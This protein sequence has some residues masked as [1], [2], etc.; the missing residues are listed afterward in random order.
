MSLSE[1]K[2]SNA[3]QLKEL[4]AK[5]SSVK[6][7]LTKFKKHLDVVC[8]SKLSKM[9]VKELEISIDKIRAMSSK[10]DELQAQIEVINCDNMDSEI[11]ERDEIEQIFISHLAI[12]E[13]QLDKYKATPHHSDSHNL[14][15]CH[16][17]Q[18]SQCHH[19]DFKL[20]QIQ[21]T[22]F[23]GEY[24]RWLE[25]RDTYL[26]LIHNNER[27]KPIHKFHYLVSYLE[28]EAAR[29]ISNLEICAVN[30]ETAW[31][32]LCDR[33]DN[34]RQLINQHLN[35]LLYFKPTEQQ[36]KRETGKSLRFL[37]DHVTKNL[38]ALSSLAKQDE[39]LDMII[40]KMLIP[41]LDNHTAM[42]WEEHRNCLSDLPTLKDFNKFLNDRADVLE[43]LS[44]NKSD[45][46]ETTQPRQNNKNNSRITKS[47]S[48]T[49]QNTGSVTRHCVACKG[50]HWIYDC[51]TFLAKSVQER[52]DEAFKLH[53]CSNCLRIG[54][55]ARDCKLGPCRQCK[56]RH[57]SLLHLPNSNNSSTSN[58][59]TVSGNSPNSDRGFSEI[60]VNNSTS[61]NFVQN[62]ILLSTAMVN[63]INPQT[64]KQFRVRALLDC[65]S[66]SSFISQSLM[67]KLSLQV[68]AINT[69][70]V[71]GIGNN[72][73]EH[74]NKS[75]IA[76][77]NSV[78]NEY[79]VVQ[80]FYV[81]N[82]LTG[83]IPKQSIDISQ[84]NIP[85]D[86]QLADPNFN[87]PSAIDILIGADLFWD[88]LGCD[89]LALGHNMPKLRSSKLGWLVAGPIS[90][91][92]RNRSSPKTIPCHVSINDSDECNNSDI[93][94][95]LTKFWEL[96]QVP[97]KQYFSK[98]EQACEDHFYR[99]T[100][101]LE[102]GRFCV[103]LPLI[104]TPDCLGDSY[105]M[106]KTR[107]LYLEKRFRK[108]PELRLQYSN[109]IQEY[110]D[111]GHLEECP[112]VHP[113]PS[114]YLCHHAV[115]KQNSETTKTRVVFDG[116]ARTSSG[117]SLNDL[118]M[119]GPN[120]Q[121]SIF[122]ILIRARQY[123]YI[124]TADI[125]KFFRMV[126]LDERD[127]NFQLI[128]WRSHESNPIKTLRLKTVTYGLASA[129]YLSTKCLSVLAEDCDDQLIS[130]IIKHDHYVDD[131][132][133][134]SNN[135]SELLYIQRKVSDTLK[136][137]G[138]KLRKFRSN[139][140]SILSSS[141]I[142]P[143]DKVSLSES[144]NTLGLN[145]NPKTD[146]F[147]IS[148]V[149]PNK[150]DVVTKRFIL[151][152]S[153]K[154]FDPLGLL[155]PCVIIPKMLLQS[156]WLN[157]RSWDETVSSDILETWNKFINDLH[158]LS[159]LQ[160]PRLT[161]CEDPSYIEI[162]TFSDASQVAYGACVYL[163]SHNLA[164]EVKV[165]LLCAKSKVAPLKPTTI[166]R[167][168]LCAAL[169]AA[170]LCKA[171]TCSL[172]CEVNRIIHWCDSSVVLSWLNGNSA[173]LKTFVANRVAEINELTNS[174]SWRY[175]STDQNP[176]DLIS[177][178]VSPHQIVNFN[179]W[180]SGPNFLTQSESGW[181]Y[182]NKLLNETEL[183]EMKSTSAVVQEPVTEILKI[184]KFSSFLKLRRIFAYVNRFIHNIRL[185]N[186]KDKLLGRFSVSELELSFISLCKIAQQTSFAA[187]YNTLLKNK[188]LCRKSSLL[189]LSPFLDDDKVIRV[190]GRLELSN[191]NYAKKHPILLHASHP[192]TKLYFRH[193]HLQNMHA[194]PQLLLACVRETVWPV[195]GRHL[196]RRT[197]HD[198]VRCK[199]IQGKTLTPMMGNL[200]AQRITPDFPFRTVGVDFA[201]PFLTI[202]R[203]G[204]G[205]R[206][207]KTYLC[208]FV[209][210]RYKCLHLE[211]VS[212]L[213][214][215]AFIMTLRRF[216]SR[217]GKP[218]EI[219]CDNGR[220]FVA[221]AKEI[222]HFLKTSH[223]SVVDF[224]TN[225]GVKFVFSPTYAPHFGG[226]WEAGVKS[227]KFHLKRVMGNNHLTF[228]EI[229]TLFTQV[230]AVLNSRPLCPL[231]PSPN[232]YHFLTPG[233]FLI[234]R[235]L[236]A[237]PGPSLEHERENNLQRYM[238]LEQIHQHFWQRWQR[239][240]VAELQQRLKWRT[241]TAS[242]Q[243][244]DLV[245]L[246]EDNVPPLN[247]RMG[248][249][250][251]LFP[252]TD[253]VTRVA[254]VQTTRGCFRRPFTRICPL[255]TALTDE[256]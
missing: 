202:N 225:E 138:F 228:E 52:R 122:S 132:V 91:G 156:L 80:S 2:D 193:E 56:R 37:V 72:L 12:A 136:S 213:S 22:K 53:L 114:Y 209:C 210:F 217:R 54:H 97:D 115:F 104:D 236:N 34:K 31:Q 39:L 206:L 182:L 109:F 28:N 192:F 200:P 88:L 219:F 15:Q 79:S 255:P 197:V 113:V 108:N 205:A 90:K 211:A 59:S 140:P 103:R 161:L 105:A 46:L 190:G 254:D 73:A 126:E 98:I 123:R 185:K 96:E 155:S 159:N 17:D 226:I 69:I 252:G 26:S 207:T 223:E 32:L 188:T 176:A 251:R 245:L 237:L 227:A 235:A 168:E 186:P 85:R 247:W 152:T 41:K 146:M 181:P 131:L 151:S 244:G 16:H 198:C 6:G 150:N 222:G 38:R 61:D 153:F 3:K 142:D 70:N 1:D 21:I 129:T 76:G 189:S 250:S 99:N 125:E 101:R 48:S 10:F 196:A 63:V 165:N 40:I 249:I 36:N 233:H 84:L 208:L 215:D 174:S 130:N 120:V 203:K 167:L 55:H 29:I 81:L 195:N 19:I 243:V 112:I 248:R 135:E 67:N 246:Q 24:F 30:Y 218:A 170:K 102:S 60:S 194:G 137:G 45:T 232:D 191:Y 74:V 87:Q 86:I 253:G 221:A 71:I 124:L 119:V 62:Y 169:L 187:E 242:L 58:S 94:S 139:L 163:R 157:K 144:T 134:G 93:N 179:L 201:G 184:D 4:Y 166:P 230:E 127:R 77:L 183:P 173:R 148:I 57:N 95:Q 162:H 65:G 25:F 231:S 118:Q 180:W 175:V 147:Q 141:V 240:Y 33:Y 128:L 49:V 214:K 68:C 43:T 100:Y 35:S 111:L 14:S 75:C 241:K 212:D 92:F 11:D 216:I 110:L 82:Q 44:Q 143:N 199:R 18:T 117:F 50:D 204:R 149:I 106:A 229:C 89:Q 20:P 234:G 145:W 64:N 47:F 13:E 107:L 172:R 116:S 177:R 23:N 220:N 171:V 66:Q 224:A 9:Q 78:D 8:S 256:D 239:E 27:I 83:A 164:G 133:T 51:P 238:K 160:I 121:D 7:R 5:R 154:I 42:K 158:F 178:G